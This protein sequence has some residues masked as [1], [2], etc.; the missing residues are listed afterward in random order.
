MPITPAIENRAA[1]RRRLRRSGSMV[2]LS[3]LATTG[4]LGAYLGNPRLTRSYAAATYCGGGGVVNE[5]GL[6]AAIATYVAN[7]ASCDTILVSG[8]ITLTADIPGIWTGAPT[9]S[10]AAISNAVPLTIKG[11]GMAP[12]ID[13]ASAWSGFNAYLTGGL[14]IDG[15]VMQNFLTSSTTAPDGIARSAGAAVANNGPVTVTGSFFID[16]SV[17]VTSGTGGAVSAQGKVTVTNSSFSG[18][19]ASGP[20]GAIYSAGDV[21]V[22]TSVF[23]GNSASNG[24]AIRGSGAV[25]LTN[26]QFTSNTTVTGSGGALYNDPY[27]GAGSTTVTGSTFSA[28]TAA[29]NG[30]AIGSAWISD[31][32]NSTFD[33][34]SADGNGGAISLKAIFEAGNE[35]NFSTFNGNSAAQG[36]ALY[37]YYASNAAVTNS[38][39]WGNAATDAGDDVYGYLYAT[40]TE[41]YN[42]LS[43]STSMKISEYPVPAAQTPDATDVVGQ[44]PNLGALADNGGTVMAY[45]TPL[46][47]MALP[48]GSPALD[49][50][51]PVVATPTTDERGTGFVRVS[52][53]RA[54]MGAFE[55]QSSAGVTVAVTPYPSTKSVKYGYGAPTFKFKATTGTPPVAFAGS[56]TTVPTCALVLPPPARPYGSGSYGPVLPVGVY[57]VVCSGGVG[58]DGESVTYTDGTFTVIP[59]YAVKVTPKAGSWTVGQTPPSLGYSA[60]GF[61]NGE[62]FASSG[63]TA[64]TCSVFTG[65]G[66][67]GSPV[68]IDSATP[69]GTYYNHCSGAVTSANYV[70]PVQYGSGGVVKV[71]AAV[72]PTATR[73]SPTYGYARG[74]TKVHIYGSGFVAGTTVT[75]GGVTCTRVVVQ[76]YGTEVDCYTGAHAV[77]LVDVVVTTPG[78]TATL[79]NGYR[80]K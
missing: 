72:T 7:P 22:A 13:G 70:S 30:G 45:I 57:P 38:I 80:Y 74:G 55:L 26:S 6:A 63:M 2:G 51:N 21:E 15:V 71:L 48:A 53:S 1:R 33:A 78:G 23:T 76:R 79:T 10:P 32:T 28:N 67:T 77:G 47:T 69:A 68:T 61:K 58:S 65:L 5:S 62:T 11:P 20:G 25:T 41:S 59:A 29:A 19:S 52:N 40:I 37:V 46:L 44:N 24:G 64:P 39:F 42:L 16:N 43:N 31:V 12:T 73:M 60:S 8:N 66:G 27:S 75:I 54:D 4:L 50:A 49:V 17:T 9:A 14:I 56:W 18:N 36:G 35:V 3:M 34:N